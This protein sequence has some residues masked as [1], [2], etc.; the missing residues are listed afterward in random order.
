MSRQR[1]TTGRPIA[2]AAATAVTLRA[3]VE[4]DCR[5]AWRW[6]NDPETRRASFDSAPIPFDTH[7][8]WFAESLARADRKLYI[9]M[10]ADRPVGVARLDLDGGTATVSLHIAPEWRGRKI[11]PA[12]LRALADVAFGRL[13]LDRLEASIKRDNARSLAAFGQAGFVRTREGAMVKLQRLR[14]A[15]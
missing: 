10:A 12:A 15:R 9:V 14:H 5:D 11:G 1:A 8:R 6:R 7:E 3:A 4:M 2:A 13:G